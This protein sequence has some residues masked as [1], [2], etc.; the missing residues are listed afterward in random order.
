MK[1]I[2]TTEEA[3][4]GGEVPVLEVAPE[5]GDEQLAVEALARAAGA[6]GVR[7]SDGHGLGAIRLPLIARMAREEPL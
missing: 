4:C 1:W 3:G 2:L 6:E 7:V 5:S